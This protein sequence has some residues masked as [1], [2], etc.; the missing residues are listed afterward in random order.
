MKRGY[1]LI[2]FKGKSTE[3]ASASI[4]GWGVKDNSKVLGL[5]TR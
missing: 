2:Y 4:W 3:F 1:I 5:C